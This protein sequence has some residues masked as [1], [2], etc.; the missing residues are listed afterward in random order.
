ME[1]FNILCIYSPNYW[2]H[3]WRYILEK[4][5][6]DLSNNKNCRRHNT[7]FTSFINVCTNKFCI[8]FH[9]LED[10]RGINPMFVPLSYTEQKYWST[11][12]SNKFGFGL[13]QLLPSILYKILED[14]YYESTLWFCGRIIPFLILHPKKRVRCESASYLTKLSKVHSNY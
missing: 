6:K 14:F 9:Y 1:F 4:K 11:T 2:W 7:F 5:K 3:E 8:F 13:H 10:L 12:I